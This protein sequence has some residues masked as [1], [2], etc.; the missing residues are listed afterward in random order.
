MID[1][2][3]KLFLD[4]KVRDYNQPF[5]IKNDPV[6]IPHR[7]ISQADIEISG[8]FAAVFAWGNRATIINKCTELMNLMDNAPHS[9][10]VHHSDNDL[11]KLLTFRHRTFNATDLLYFVDFFKQH[12]SQYKSLEPAFSNWMQQDDETVENGRKGGINSA[13]KRREQKE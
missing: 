10:C 9:F 12:Y 3:L 7:F 5:F 6:C 4:E 2:K 1:E 8:F 11:K 13:K